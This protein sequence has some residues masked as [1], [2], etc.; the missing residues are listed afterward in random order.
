MDRGPYHVTGNH[1]R[2][3]H[4]IIEA[5]SQRFSLKD[6]GPL[7]YFLGIEVI[8]FSAG[9]LL[10]QEK[11]TMDLLHYVAMDNCK[12]DGSLYLHIIGKLHYLSFTRPDRGFAV[13]KLSQAMHQPF[14][15][16]CVALTRL[17]RY[18]RSTISFGVL[19]ANETDRRLLAYSDSDWEGDPHDCISTTG[20]VIYPVSS[21]ISWS[22]KKQ[23]SI[24]HSSTEAEYRA[25][26]ATVSE[27]NWL[28]HFLQELQFPL[29]V[30]PRVL[31]DN[32]STT[33]ICA[34]PVFHSRMKHVAIYFH[35][36]REQ[37]EQNSLKL[38]IYMLLIKLKIF[39]QSLFRVHFLVTISPS[40][41]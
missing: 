26:A 17:L 30:V 39:L 22:S 3:V 31:C 15:S 13:S 27:I 36:V 2:D 5:L 28:T 20:Y 7:H 29:T 32:I 11:Y 24:S 25:V 10:S 40:W 14:L 18:L 33:Y 41:A 8:R 23:R 21:P 35:F 6:L 16:H 1:Q 38:P 19:I 12:V 4:Y 34:N 9:L 37:V